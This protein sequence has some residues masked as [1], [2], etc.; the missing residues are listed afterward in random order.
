MLRA[1]KDTL[2]E[3]YQRY[4][5]RPEYVR[6]W[7]AVLVEPV[8]A[9]ATLRDLVLSINAKRCPKWRFRVADAI[10]MQLQPRPDQGRYDMHAGHRFTGRILAGPGITKAHFTRKDLGTD[11]RDIPFSIDDGATSPVRWR[12]RVHRGPG[13]R[14]ELA[15]WQALKDQLS[16]A[17]P[18]L[19]TLER[20]LMFQPSCLIC[21]KPLSDPVS[22]ARWIGPECAHSHALDVG[23]FQLR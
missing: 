1:Q 8:P 17:L 7:E 9:L 22:M 12:V 16:A 13:P 14:H 23:V 21:G 15:P 3:E 11:C 18:R 2:R 6:Y 20:A 19:N 10:V 4:A 5:Q